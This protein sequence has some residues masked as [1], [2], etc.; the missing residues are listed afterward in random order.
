MSD[1][2]SVICLFVVL[3]CLACLSRLFFD[4]GAHLTLDLLN[5]T[6]RNDRRL[7]V[8]TDNLFFQSER[9][10]LISQGKNSGSH[11]SPI[12][13]IPVT[14]PSNSSSAS[15]G[16]KRRHRKTHGK[17]GFAAL[18]RNIASKWKGLDA[19]SRASFSE[20]ATVEKERYMKDLEIWKRSQQE[21][22]R[23]KQAAQQQK[24][25]KESE[26]DGGRV[27]KDEPLQ[28]QDQERSF[29]LKGGQIRECQS[30]RK[31]WKLLPEPKEELESGT[32]GIIVVSGVLPP[33]TMKQKKIPEEDVIISILEA[34]EENTSVPVI[35]TGL[36]PKTT[37]EPPL[38]SLRRYLDAFDTN[39][40]PNSVKTTM[41][42]AFALTPMIEM[43]QSA[44]APFT[45]CQYST[46]EPEPNP[47]LHSPSA[48]AA[49]TAPSR[50]TKF[51]Q[52]KA[53]QQ[54]QP[55]K[56]DYP[57]TCVVNQNNITNPAAMMSESLYMNELARN[58]DSIFDDGPSEGASAGASASPVNIEDPSLQQAFIPTDMMVGDR[59][60]RDILSSL[61][62]LD[63]VLDDDFM[64]FIKGY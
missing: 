28:D 8:P 36:P 2:D 57:P 43:G 33:Q 32:E 46:R 23:P 24:E 5:L 63:A 48:S 3:S 10:K 11:Q 50:A 14:S 27:P 55:L 51:H 4:I 37:T 39:F 19:E 41:M 61:E 35:G 40:E 52:A 42:N 58:V 49:A 54:Q 6:P 53:P 17:I 47:S 62:S 21:K 29:E 1:S 13:Q 25:S 45:S 56:K 15:F 22:E 31:K 12:T 34:A 16:P 9:K 20:R 60:M 26:Q 44:S 7:N 18:A 38:L 30:L 59:G 64:E